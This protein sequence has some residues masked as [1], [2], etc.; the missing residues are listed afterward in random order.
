MHSHFYPLCY[1]DCVA[2]FSIDQK[3]IGEE[4]RAAR[5]YLNLTLKEVAEKAGIAP[6]HVWNFE[7]GERELSLERFVSLCGALGLPPGQL[8]AEKLRINFEMLI[9]LAVPKFRN[10]KANGTEA[11]EHYAHV[12]G[13]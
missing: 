12:C 5:E 3:S 2:L 8:L 1:H 6:S 13:I 10:A 4:L 7:H 9:D 11:T